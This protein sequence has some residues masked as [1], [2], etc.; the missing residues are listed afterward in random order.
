MET[1]IFILQIARENQQIV[2]NSLILINSFFN[3]PSRVRILHVS[4]TLEKLEQNMK[5]KGES[6]V[7]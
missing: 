4:G 2:Q 1:K 3:V 6:A 7:N 5:L